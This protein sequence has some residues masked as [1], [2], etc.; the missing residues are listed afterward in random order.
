MSTGMERLAP[1][2]LGP[3]VFKAVKPAATALS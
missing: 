2:I 1:R 3:P